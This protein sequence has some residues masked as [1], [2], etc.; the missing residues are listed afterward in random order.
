MFEM[1]FGISKEEYNE[2]L[3]SWNRL[4]GDNVDLL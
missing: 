4:T 1:M 2:C 3:V